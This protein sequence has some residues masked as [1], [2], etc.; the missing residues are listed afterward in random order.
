MRRRAFTLIELLVVIA[1]IAILAAILFPVFA[2]AR[3]SARR[4][5]CA[6]NMKQVTMG[7]LMYAQDY[8]ETFPYQDGD[9]C[10]YANDPRAQWINAV[11][12]YTKNAQIWWCPSAR[13]QSSAGNNG[14]S[15]YWYNGHASRKA[16]SAIEK[17]SESTLFAEWMYRT[18][19]TG[20]RPYENQICGVVRRDGTCPDTW[21]A[22]SEWGSNHVTGDPVN[23][24]GPGAQA[25]IRGGNWPYVDGHIKFRRTS[26]V[27]QDW[28]N[29]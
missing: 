21:H 22:R 2:Q 12:P 6:N 5:T 13:R 14:D 20:R 3:E 28:V 9:R 11:T 16:L 18:N 15:N 29:Y 1:I 26:Q 8:D 19:C 7:L 25:G 24:S 23:A 4:T 17:P 27:M 10:P